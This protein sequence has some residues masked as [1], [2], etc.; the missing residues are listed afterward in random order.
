MVARLGLTHLV[1][2]FAAIAM[3]V[4]SVSTAKSGDIVIE[5]PE[6]PPLR[7]ANC[8]HATTSIDAALVLQYS[9]GLLDDFL[10]CLHVTDMNTDCFINALDAA[11]VLQTTAGLL[12]E[13]PYEPIACP[14]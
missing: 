1:G 10:P 6:P 4:L 2:A 8:D 9:A 13:L 14:A 11:L 5:T 12:P 3:T 7:D